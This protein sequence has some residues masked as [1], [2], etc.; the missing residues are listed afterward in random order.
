[1]QS[2]FILYKITP[3]EIANKTIPA[4]TFGSIDK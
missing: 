4:K 3:K 1:M 2:K